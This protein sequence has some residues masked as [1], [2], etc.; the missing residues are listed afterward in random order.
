[1][2]AKT[3]GIEDHRYQAVNAVSPAY[4][5]EHSHYAYHTE[6]ESH[7]STGLCIQAPIHASL[8]EKEGC[9]LVY[10]GTEVTFRSLNSSSA[11]QVISIRVLSDCILVRRQSSLER[12]SKAPGQLNITSEYIMLDMFEFQHEN[13]C[14]VSLL[15]MVVQQSSL[16][17]LPAEHCMSMPCTP[18]HQQRACSLVVH[19]RDPCLFPAATVAPTLGS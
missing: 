11:Q 12:R 8:Y 4:A 7:G 6:Y 16:L 3:P 18:Y 1:M 19:I 9:M 2:D 17:E 5:A 10:V 14:C 15:C 13:K